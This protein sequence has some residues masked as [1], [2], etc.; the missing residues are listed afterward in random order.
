M[1]SE[2]T[3]VLTDAMSE[4]KHLERERGELLKQPRTTSRDDRLDRLG[5]SQRHIVDLMAAARRDHEGAG[6]R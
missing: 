5:R 4:L 3:G 2:E 6:K 1:T